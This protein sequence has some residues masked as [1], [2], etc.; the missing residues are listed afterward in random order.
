M[1]GGWCGGRYDAMFRALFFFVFVFFFFLFFLFLVV[2][3]SCFSHSRQRRLHYKYNSE[4]DWTRVFDGV[5]TWVLQREYLPIL[6]NL[7][8]GNFGALTCTTRPGSAGIRTSCG[9]P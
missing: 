1:S 9:W 3:C 8:D 2:T 4:M 7:A 6:S 5:T